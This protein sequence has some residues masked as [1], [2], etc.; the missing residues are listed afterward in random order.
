MLF[1]RFMARQ[2]ARPSGLFGRWVM[3]GKLDRARASS[4]A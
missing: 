2:L 4:P 3:G 1:T